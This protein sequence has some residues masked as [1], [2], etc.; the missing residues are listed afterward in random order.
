M[1]GFKRL[2]IIDGKRVPKDKVDASLDEAVLEVVTTIVVIQ[3]ILVAQNFAAV[4]HCNFGSNS[5]SHSLHAYRP[6]RRSRR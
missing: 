5:E 6:R 1:K 4:E 3:G 2:Y